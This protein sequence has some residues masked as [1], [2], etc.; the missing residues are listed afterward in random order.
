MAENIEN[1]VEVET[2]FALVRLVR[3]AS[4]VYSRIKRYL[5]ISTEGMS[6]A[7]LAPRIGDTSNGKQPETNFGSPGHSHPTPPTKKPRQR[8]Q[9]DSLAYALTSGLAGG[10]AGTLLSS[11]SLSFLGLES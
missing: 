9:Q 2:G 6:T 11:S 8:P 5:S 4:P 7:A 1:R 10:I 3:S